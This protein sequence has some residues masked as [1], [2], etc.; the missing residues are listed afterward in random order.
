MMNNSKNS[1]LLVDPEFDPQ[2]VSSCNLL[3]KVTE[4]SFSYAI[5]DTDQRRLKVI[6]DMQECGPVFGALQQTLKNDSYLRLPFQ[7]IKAAIFS[8][9]QMNVP[10]VVFQQDEAAVYQNFFPAGLS[11]NLYTRNC[12]EF[13]FTTVFNMEKSIVNL[14]EMHLSGA[15]LYHLHT[16]ALK[17]AA[18]SEQGLLLLDFTAGSF[19]A[20]LVE[21]GKLIYLNNF[22]FAETA[23]FN[24]YILLIIKQL[25]LDTKTINLQ[26]SGI[27]HQE[28]PQ[29]N[30]LRK[31]FSQLNFIYPPQLDIDQTLLDDMPGHYYSTLIAFDLCV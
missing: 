21:N 14:I 22:E 31:Y 11:G 30:C 19:Q 28:D 16:P 1:I 7:K 5:I 3:L 8:P 23:E 24:Y 12:E 18:S 2:T 29:Y 26:L 13:G 15:E 17:L 27:I 6:F 20:V 9:Y 25:E 10:N 4:E